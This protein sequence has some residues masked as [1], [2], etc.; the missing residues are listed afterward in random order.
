MSPNV[1]NGITEIV[2]KFSN[3]WKYTLYVFFLKNLGMIPKVQEIMNK[4]CQYGICTYVKPVLGPESRWCTYT[5][6]W[7]D[8][9]ILALVYINSWTRHNE[10][11]YKN[12]AWRNIIITRQFPTSSTMKLVT[13]KVIF[14]TVR[15]Q[16]FPVSITQGKD[17]YCSSLITF[18]KIFLQSSKV[19]SIKI[20]DI[21]CKHNSWKCCSSSQISLMSSVT[22]PDR[23]ISKNWNWTHKF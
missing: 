23:N 22:Q 9:L 1:P 4:Y 20:P 14:I 2:S 12:N 7:L 11:E 13:Y 19:T 18:F 8:G 16:L 5:F 10:Y 3:S 21:C 15:F 6:F 17:T